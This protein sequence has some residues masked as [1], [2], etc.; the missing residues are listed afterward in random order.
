MLLYSNTANYAMLFTANVPQDDEY[1]SGLSVCSNEASE[2][3]ETHA[4]C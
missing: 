4:W 2:G 1:T 3:K